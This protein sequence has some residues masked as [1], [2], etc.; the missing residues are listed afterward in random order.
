MDTQLIDGINPSPLDAKILALAEQQPHNPFP[1]VDRH[2][3]VLNEQGQMYR[4]VTF[5]APIEA[6]RFVDACTGLGLIDRV[7]FSDTLLMEADSLT[8]KPI[9]TPFA[10]ILQVGTEPHGLPV[11]PFKS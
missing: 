1:G 3:A 8:G 9:R 2:V 10:A 5:G 6:S 11:W 4:V 7:G